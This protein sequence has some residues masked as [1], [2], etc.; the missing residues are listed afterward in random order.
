MRKQ[1]SRTTHVLSQPLT[2]HQAQCAAALDDL[3]FHAS[4]CSKEGVGWGDSPK[5][6]RAM[7]FGEDWKGVVEASVSNPALVG[8]C[9]EARS[10]LISSQPNN[11]TPKGLVN[12]MWVV[13][14]GAHCRR[15]RRATYSA[16][17]EQCQTGAFPQA[18]S[19]RCAG[20]YPGRV[21]RRNLAFG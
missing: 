20:T 5:R 15:C 10:S 1:T 7:S 11:T 4:I 14:P 12:R 6:M 8:R 9:Q 2:L 18:P 17:T 21:S 13:S 19:R 16:V 3:L